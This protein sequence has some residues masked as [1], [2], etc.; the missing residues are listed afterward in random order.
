MLRRLTLGR[1]S[2]LALV[3]WVLVFIVGVSPVAPAG[4]LA[5]VTNEKSDDVSVIDTATNKVVRTIKVGKRPRGVAISP[6]G[7]RVY[8]S[9]GN[10]DS[11]SVINVEIGKQIE[12]WL[13]GVDPEGPVHSRPRSSRRWG[14]L[15]SSAPI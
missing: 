11:V 1:R 12:A 7:Q 4:P 5:Y 6:D 14:R 9:N 13:A 8:I 15:D 2:L 3:S 10:S